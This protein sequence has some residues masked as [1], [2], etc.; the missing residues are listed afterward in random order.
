VIDTLLV[1]GVTAEVCVN[2]TLRGNRGF[3]C[4]V[5][6]DCFGS[7]FPEFHEMGLAMVEAE[8]GMFG[9]VS[10]SNIAQNVDGASVSASPPPV[11]PKAA[12][13]CCNYIR[14]MAAIWSSGRLVRRG[15]S[16]SQSGLV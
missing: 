3:R 10:G 11:E 12:T 9:S 7:Y 4:I 13:R 1:C 8:G 16:R 14:L 15:A 2:T 5:V 6:A